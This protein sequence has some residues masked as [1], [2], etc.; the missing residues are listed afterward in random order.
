MKKHKT[1]KMTVREFASSLGLKKTGLDY[2]GSTVLMRLLCKKGIARKVGKVALTKM[3]RPSD[4]F[5]VPV[6]FTLKGKRRKS[7]AA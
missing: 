2:L 7:E 3:G 1:V 6:E 5:E 4:I